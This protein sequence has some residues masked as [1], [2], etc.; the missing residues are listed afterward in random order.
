MGYYTYYELNEESFELEDFEEKFDEITGYKAYSVSEN[1]E[2]I[3]WYD[4]EKDM[5]KLSLLYPKHLFIIKGEGEESGDIWK[6]YTQNG[7]QI[8]HKGEVVFPE[9]VHSQLK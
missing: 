4:C 6:L 9:F 8:K 5:I 2:S 3:K 1:G 7:K